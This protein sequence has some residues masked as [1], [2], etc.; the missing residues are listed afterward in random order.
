[1]YYKGAAGSGAAGT[2]AAGTG[3]AG[4]GAATSGGTGMM[5]SGN[6]LHQLTKFT[7]VYKLV[8]FISVFY[9]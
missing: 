4:T 2:G 6:G 3:A 9:L 7:K 8:R 5:G 1:L